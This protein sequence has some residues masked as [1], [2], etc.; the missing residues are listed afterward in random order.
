V[1]ELARQE[2][3]DRTARNAARRSL[4]LLGVMWDVEQHEQRGMVGH[5]AS[6]NTE[7]RTIPVIAEQ[8]QRMSHGALALI[9]AHIDRRR[10][11]VD[12]IEQ[13]P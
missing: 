9:G 8:Q 7:C 3:R 1:S 13:A 11:W 4:E 5:R 10:G 12:L 2:E 6:H